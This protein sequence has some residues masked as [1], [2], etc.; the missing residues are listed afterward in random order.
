MRL[1][2]PW[3]PPNGSDFEEI[4]H[5]NGAENLFAELVQRYAFRTGLS[6]V[7]PKVLVP[8]AAPASD[9]K[10]S[11]ATSDL[12]VKA[13]GAEYPASPST[14]SSACRSQ[15]RP[16]SQ[17]QNS[18]FST[19]GQLFVIRRF[20]RGPDARALGFEDMTVLMGKR[21]VDEYDG[22][23]EAVARAVR[24]FCAVEHVDKDL[25]QL[26]DQVALSCIVGNGDAHL[27]LGVV[28]TSPAANDAR[29]APAFDIVNTTAYIPEDGLALNLGGT[30][31]PFCLSSHASRLRRSLQIE[32]PKSRIQGV[33]AAVEATLKTQ[34]Q[35]LDEHPAILA[36]IR[37]GFEI[38]AKSFGD[39]LSPEVSALHRL[40][41]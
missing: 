25:A 19:N 10:A 35:L 38:F 33:L 18:I 14:N 16:A 24:L 3:R 6:G 8:E 30:Q 5:W 2:C 34:A 13:G 17:F 28:Y 23:Y 4:L 31:K 12:I 1:T 32:D 39:R 27:K 40:A 11:I 21:A 15:R 36:A 20:D 37:H 29:L 7:Q 9:G 22:S 41:R 26:F